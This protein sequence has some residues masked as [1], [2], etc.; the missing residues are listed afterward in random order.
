MII[1]QEQEL[2]G[3]KKLFRSPS[4]DTQH[5]PMSYEQVILVCDAQWGVVFA[6]LTLEQGIKITLYFWK[7]SGLQTGSPSHSCNG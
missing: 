4:E 3:K 1:Q 7:R 6:F 5:V 2:N